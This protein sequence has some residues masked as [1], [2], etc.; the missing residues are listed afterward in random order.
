MEWRGLDSSSAEFGQTAG[1]S[2]EGNDHSA[3]IK[4]RKLLEELKYCELLMKSSRPQR[5]L[6]GT[7]N[8]NLSATFVYRWRVFGRQCAV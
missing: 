2:K 6:L 8:M 7:N 1:F 5:H 4:Y 3:H